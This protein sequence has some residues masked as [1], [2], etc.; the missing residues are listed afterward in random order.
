MLGRGFVIVLALT[1]S[2]SAERKTKA[3]VLFERGLTYMKAS[4]YDRA[5]TV[6]KASLDAEFQLDTLYGLAGCEAAR[7]HIVVAWHLFQRLA[8]EEPNK[9]RK[10]RW[11]TLLDGIAAR[12]PKLEVL[13]DH[14]NATITIDGEK[15]TGAVPVDLGDHVVTVDAPGFDA[16]EQHVTVD[17]EG[18]TTQVEVTLH[19]PPVI[20]PV[21]EKT[22]H[23]WRHGAGK[24]F[25]VTGGLILAGGLG[26]GAFAYK[27]YDGTEMPGL[28]G[29]RRAIDDAATAHLW[30][31]VSTVLTA[32]GAVT[33]LGGFLL[34]RGGTRTVTVTGE[35]AIISG[36][37]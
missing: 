28:A 4:D 19:K 29:D 6:F 9:K 25:M 5:C 32:A 16:W 10:K 21:H 34:W 27:K 3:Q 11:Q 15:V 13:V 7:G 26:A 17:E 35:G 36:T 8:D 23:T 24:A 37:F 31:N 12:V 2:A 33:L 18:Q 14:P 20:V 30:G 1:A 22:V